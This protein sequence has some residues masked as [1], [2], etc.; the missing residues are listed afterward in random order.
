MTTIAPPAPAVEPVTVTSAPRECPLTAQQCTVSKCY[1]LNDP[2][3]QA[4]CNL[5]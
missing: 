4:N 5:C 3:A 2:V 1:N